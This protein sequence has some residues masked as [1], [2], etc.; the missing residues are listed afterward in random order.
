M[1]RL[2]RRWGRLPGI[3]GLPLIIVASNAMVYI[4]EMFSPGLVPH[5]VLAPP[6]IY[7]GQLWRLLT[8]L[9]VP[10][11]QSPFSMFFWLYLLYI[12]ASALENEW[13][14]FRFTLFYLVGA[15]ATAAVGFVHVFGIVPNIYLNAS[16][17]LAF[18]ALFPDFE[19]LLF[20][21]LPLK[22]KYLGYLTLRGSSE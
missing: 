18:T 9:F 17:F 8:F 2:P 4:F 16:L 15:A 22:V 14:S 5:L 19:L 20:F 6:A 1:I 10:P 7:D 12:Y 11:R 3:E 21:V 13:G